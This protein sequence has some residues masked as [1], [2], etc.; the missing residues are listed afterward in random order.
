MLQ[1]ICS[2]L[3]VSIKAATQP[4]ADGGVKGILGDSQW[5]SWSVFRAF[6]PAA[7]T[8]FICIFTNTKILQYANVETFIVFR[9]STPILVAICDSL[10]TG[11]QWPSLPAFASLGV[12]F[13]GALTYMA[14]DSAFTVSI[15]LLGLLCES[16]FKL[17]DP[18]QLIRRSHQVLSF[19]DFVCKSFTWF[20][21]A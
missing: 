14:T 21:G 6:F 10:F 7:L 5:F 3:F 15:P 19:S 1:Y 12:I 17:S 9:S 4:K 20:A 8:Y 2:V 16:P 13:F 18:W 11:R